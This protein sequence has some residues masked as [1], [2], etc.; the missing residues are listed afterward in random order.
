M[1]DYTNTGGNV[2]EREQNY[3]LVEAVTDILFTGWRLGAGG[4]LIVPDF[5]EDACRKVRAAIAASSE[6]ERIPM[7]GEPSGGGLAPW[8]GNAMAHSAA[9]VASWPKWKRDLAD[10]DLPPIPLHPASNPSQP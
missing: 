5:A 1:S 4:N 7:A 3:R 10:D 8:L 2:K 6:A 9:E